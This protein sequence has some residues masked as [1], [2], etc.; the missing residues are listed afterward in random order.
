MGICVYVHTC[1]FNICNVN[2]LLITPPNIK[3]IKIKFRPNIGRGSEN[4]P[5][6]CGAEQ[7]A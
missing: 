5:D 4:F 1:I 3:S 6:L 7:I 2:V